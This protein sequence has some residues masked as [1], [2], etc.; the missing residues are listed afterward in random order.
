MAFL[1]HI[2][3]YSQLLLSCA[4]IVH[5]APATDLQILI[6]DCSGINPR[7]I[8]KSVSELR[9]IL[10][11][12]EADVDVTGCRDEASSASA[13]SSQ[14]PRLLELWI[15]RGRANMPDDCRQPLGYSVMTAEAVT[16]LSSAKQL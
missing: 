8:E 13:E 11:F 15:L 3:V 10:L 9:T 4:S 6:H 5:L 1:A 14:D 16:R 12:A 7:T 2:R